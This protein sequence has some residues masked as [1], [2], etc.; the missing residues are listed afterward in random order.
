M[1]TPIRRLA[2]IENGD[3]RT[4]FVIGIDHVQIAAPRGCEQEARNFF[5]RLL[6]L[7]EIEKPAPLRSRGGCWFKVGSRQ[8]HIGVEEDF[9]PAGKAHPAF[10]VD[11]IEKAFAVM[12]AAGVRCV[13]DDAHDGIR[14]FYAADPWG[15][16]LE[17]TEPTADGKELPI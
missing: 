4:M 5:G 12:A 17:F 8:L 15:N 14:R 10:A 3:N 7:E 16:R 9:R 13:W 2:A 1:F 11:D 6:G